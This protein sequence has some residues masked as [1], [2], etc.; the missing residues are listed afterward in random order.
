MQLPTRHTS[1]M[2]RHNPCCSVWNRTRPHIVGSVSRKHDGMHTTTFRADVPVFVFHRHYEVYCKCLVGEAFGK[3][4]ICYLC[5]CC[6]FSLQRYYFF[7]KKTKSKVDNSKL[8]FWALPWRK[9]EGEAKEA[10][11]RRNKGC[12][13]SPFTGYEL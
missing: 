13:V 4:K 1:K 11:L 9:K 6:M 7:V 10:D 3:F 5:I 8:F 12:Q 2:Q